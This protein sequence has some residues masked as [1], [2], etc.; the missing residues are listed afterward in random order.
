MTV[1]IGYRYTY[2]CAR[3]MNVL[4]SH[5]IMYQ[6]A[7]AMEKALNNQV[8]KKRLGQVDMSPLLVTSVLSQWAHEQSSHGNR[9]EG[10][11]GAQQFRLTLTKMGPSS[12][13]SG[14]PTF[15]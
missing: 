9:D 3:S 13:P 1:I 8:E 5:T 10:Y 7:S 15:L 6:R 14:G 4:V 12:V 2:G 11:T